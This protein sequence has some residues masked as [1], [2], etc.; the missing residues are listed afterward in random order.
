M[1]T[2]TDRDVSIWTQVAFKEAARFYDGSDGSVAK[3][4]EAFSVLNGALIS[5]VKSATEANVTAAP[6]AAPPATFNAEQSMQNTFGATEGGAA[7]VSIVD[8]KFGGQ[9]GPLPQW[10]VEAA[11]KA[12]VVK[13]FDNRNR[14]AENAK[15]PWFKD[16]AQGSDTAF[17]PPR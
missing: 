14:L 15:L 4:V 11:A 8:T 16:A 17:W 9:Q 12:G 13:A 3:F 5:E 7:T 10:F 6:V 2:I 1:Q